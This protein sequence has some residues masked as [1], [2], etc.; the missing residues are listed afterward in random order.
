M[1]STHRVTTRIRTGDAGRSLLAALVVCLAAAGTAAGA[2][3]K[4]KTVLIVYE[5]G[6]NPVIS[7]LGDARQLRQLLGHFETDVTIEPADR[8]R[9]G[10]LA[11]YDVGFFVGYTRSYNP[12]PPLL[13]DVYA[14]RSTFVWLNSGL[15]EFGRAFD[16][17]ARSSARSSSRRAGSTSRSRASTASAPSRSWT[18]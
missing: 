15:V 6:P 9:A 3:E 5:P 4:A 8:Y 2:V 16:L 10:T 7:G 12:P 17:P 13:R 14:A 11:H 18:A 1:G